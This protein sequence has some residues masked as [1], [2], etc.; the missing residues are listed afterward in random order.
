MTQSLVGQPATR[1]LT[2]IVSIHKRLGEKDDIDTIKDRIIDKKGI[3]D[4]LSYLP[5][6]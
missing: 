5:L 4:T 1:A 6:R 3:M 2:G